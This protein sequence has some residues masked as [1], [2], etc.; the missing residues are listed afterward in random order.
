MKTIF[1]P[2]LVLL[3]NLADQTMARQLKD[4]VR[5]LQFVKAE[6]EVLRAHLPERI[7]VTP[8]ERRRLIRLA[9]L[10]ARPRPRPAAFI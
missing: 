7:V 9:T 8:Q 2:L 3:A 1:H 10:A 4:L 5:Q 6:N